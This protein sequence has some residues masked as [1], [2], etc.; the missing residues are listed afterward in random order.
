MSASPRLL[1]LQPRIRHYDW[2]DPTFIPRL[3]GREPTGEPWA[4]AWFGA[5]PAAPSLAETD[6]GAHSLDDLLVTAG[7]ELL[8]PD[9]RERFGGLPYLVKLLAAARPLSIQVHPDAA[10]ARAGFEREQAAGIPL[11]AHHRNY[12]DASHKPELIVALSEFHALCGFRS[13]DGVA[14]ALSALPELAAL[15]PA[16]DGTDAG[17]RRLLEQWFAL[18][19][20]TV[21][22]ALAGV[23]ERLRRAPPEPDSTADWALRAQDAMGPNTGPDRGL[24]FVYLLERLRLEPGEGMF[25][26]A[27]VPHAYLAGAG[28]EVMASSDNVLRAGLTPKHVEPDELMR[29]VRFDAR[30]PEILTG[31]YVTPAPEFELERLTLPDADGRSLVARGPELLLAMPANEA[32]VVTVTADATCLTLRRGDACLVGHGA[33]YRLGGDPATLWRCHVPTPRVGPT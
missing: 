26:P 19:E 4:E 31:P 12:R 32:G 33:G 24:L 8:G 7:A 22:P 11:D 13:P 5:H 20:T 29:I 16:F 2:G 21:R 15:L 14:D 9:L 17:L 27:G 28:I 30:A 10:Q 18:P 6:S 3:L 1:R 25:L 23:L